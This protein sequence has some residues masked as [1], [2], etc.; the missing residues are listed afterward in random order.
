MDFVKDFTVTKEPDS[1]VKIEGE[2]PFANL[3]AERS[4]ALKKLG[5]DV[6]IDGFRK[7]H[8]PEAELV[9]RIGEMNILSEMAE[10]ALAKVYPEIAKQH[11]LDIIGYP[12]V[13]ITKIAADNPLGFTL[14]VAVLPEISLPN[15][16]KLAGEIN[17][18]KASAEVTDEDVEKQI[19]D[20]LRQK[21][22][23]ER[24]QEKA[25]KKAKAES[26]DVGD[27]SASN[28]GQAGTTDLPTPETVE[29]EAETPAQLP[30][31]DESE[32]KAG[33][34][35]H[36]DGTVHDGP[37][38]A[39]PEAVK[40]EELPELTD[41]YVKEFGQPGQFSSVEDF[42]TKIREHLAIEKEREVTANHRAKVTDTIIEA[43]E[44]ELPQV[45]VDSEI[46][47]MWAQMEEDLKRA[48]L[49]MD[50]YL[51]HIKKTKEELAS[52][53]KPA[54]EKRARLQLVL[55][56]IA[57]AEE[58]KPD[59]GLV[60]TQVDQ[61]KEQYKDADEARVRVYV[62]SVLTNEAVMKLLEDA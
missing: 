56:E 7:G 6:E 45:L 15:Y 26:T 27:L 28:D 24:L 16:K 48:N 38:H 23:Y 31:S 11:K 54:A 1:Q 8:V 14:T 19:K 62:E 61:L 36:A 29:K 10:R 21:I 32:T 30:D 25:A 12:Q 33:Q 39:E 9:K 49:K 40:D 37:A 2:I 46:G 51:G 52:E 58:V 55:N 53:W 5:G 34:H 22:A 17:Q 3:V 13:N 44:M 47:Q 50:D 20:I 18:T 59:Q 57:K 41:E 4:A 42:K 35:T 60:D 43:T